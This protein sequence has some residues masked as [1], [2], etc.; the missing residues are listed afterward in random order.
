MTF[1]LRQP[2]GKPDSIYIP[3]TATYLSACVL[4][5]T[6]KATRK[7]SAVG[8]GQVANTFETRLQIV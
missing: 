8:A 6:E 1:V 5:Y 4:T 7:V 2:L 3:L